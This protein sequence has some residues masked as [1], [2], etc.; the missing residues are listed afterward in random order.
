MDNN[1]DEKKCPVCGRPNL[2]K[3]EKCWYCQAPLEE[4]NETEQKSLL[5][6]EE[7]LDQSGEGSSFV[8]SALE[9]KTANQP[10]NTPEWL[11]R[12]RELIA[13]DRHEEKPVDD[14]QQQKLFDVPENTAKKENRTE[15]TKKS[16][17]AQKQKDIQ[18]PVPKNDDAMDQQPQPSEE[19][20][21]GFTRLSTHS[22]DD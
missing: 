7:M 11:R 1:L 17:P 14:W 4:Q 19:L 20:P 8:Q 21:D 5:S 10:D 12:V 2:S 16:A 22:S 18:I 15:Q 6:N 3:A 13:A 9:E